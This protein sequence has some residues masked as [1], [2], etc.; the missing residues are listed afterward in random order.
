[1]FLSSRQ[2]GSGFFK[3]SADVRSLFCEVSYTGRVNNE[4]IEQNKSVLD[5]RAVLSYC[6]SRDISFSAGGNGACNP[7]LTSRISATAMVGPA[8]STDKGL[9]MLLGEA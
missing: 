4:L 3:R 2:V 9:K 6:M 1:M 5:C 8:T 7:A